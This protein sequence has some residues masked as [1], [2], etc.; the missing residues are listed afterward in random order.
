VKTTTEIKRNTTPKEKKK[1][2]QKQTTYPKTAAQKNLFNQHE[3]KQP[4]RADRL[5]SRLPAP[6][7]DLREARNDNSDTPVSLQTLQARVSDFK[8]D[9]SR[10]QDVVVKQQG[11]GTFHVF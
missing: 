2:N 1:T 10:S 6:C 11:R 9:F 5:Q 8:T 7:F 4:W 3:Q